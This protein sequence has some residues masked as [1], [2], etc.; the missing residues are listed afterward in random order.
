M[1]EVWVPGKPVLP[2]KEF[3]VKL[4]DGKEAIFAGAECLADWIAYFLCEAFGKDVVSVT[5]RSLDVLERVMMAYYASG[6]LSAIVTALGAIPGMGILEQYYNLAL[7]YERM[8]LNIYGSYV[9][10]L[11]SA[12]EDFVRVITGWWPKF[13][14][15]NP[16]VVECSGVQMIFELIEV[17]TSWLV[18]YV[19]GWVFTYKRALRFLEQYGVPS[20]VNHRYFTTALMAVRYAK[21]VL[22][23]VCPD[24]I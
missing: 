10:L 6:N 4:S 13:L 5:Y 11:Q 9:K 21:A 7:E 2:T 16:W 3:R 23:R 18:S 19:E 14:K 17:W 15:E 22:Q 1:P 8:A 12:V 20:I 24:K